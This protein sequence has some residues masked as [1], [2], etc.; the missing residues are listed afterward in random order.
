[1]KFKPNLKE[2]FKRLDY[3]KIVRLIILGI[4][5]IVMVIVIMPNFA[6]SIPGVAIGVPSP[7]NFK[8]PFSFYFEEKIPL[9]DRAERFA[10]PIKIPVFSTVG[11]LD[12]E[13]DEIENLLQFI[14]ENNTSFNF[15][16]LFT[17]NFS[18][19]LNIDELQFLKIV[20]VDNFKSIL[21]DYLWPE[22]VKKEILFDKK[23][24]KG[25]IT[26]DKIWIFNTSQS[27][28]YYRLFDDIV[29]IDHIHGVVKSIL[30]SYDI[31]EIQRNIYYKIIRYYVKDTIVY[32]EERTKIKNPEE[33]KKNDLKTIKIFIEKGESILQKGQIVTNKEV[34]IIDNVRMRIRREQ[35]TVILGIIILIA[36]YL[37]I[38]I[39]YLKYFQQRIL[40]RTSDM[41]ILCVLTIFILGISQ[42]VIKFL[43]PV[44][45][46]SLYNKNLYLSFYIIPL[47]AIS[48]II[49]LLLSYRLSII[50]SIFLSIF[51]G[52]IAGSDL[53]LPFILMSGA[54]VG[55]FSVRNAS[56]RTDI[57]KGGLFVTISY[58]VLL[59]AFVMIEKRD[60]FYIVSDMVC[61]GINGI[62]FTPVI[63]LG[64]LPFIENIGNLTSPFRLLELTDLNA[65]ILKEMLVAAPGTYQHSQ[66]VASLAEAAAIEI[67]ANTLLCKAGGY[68]H[69][70]GKIEKAEYYL[71]NQVPGENPHDKLKPRISAG[72][73][74]SHIKEGIE[75]AKE[76]GLPQAIIDIIAQHQGTGLMKVF[77]RDA[78]EDGEESDTQLS[79]EDFRYPGP[80]PQSKEAAIIMLADSSEAACRSLKRKSY[81]NIVEQI[82]KTINE[83][84]IDGQLDECDFNLKDL[85]KTVDIFSRMLSSLYHERI[86]YPEDEDIEK[87]KK[88]LQQ[89]TAAKQREDEKIATTENNN[90]STGKTKEIKKNEK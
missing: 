64:L 3:E 27:K 65:P 19:T 72:I 41:M 58:I 47:S 48:M 55:I 26:S 23:S 74:K 37:G 78:I 10:K 79:E 77:Y 89:K 12:K 67:G 63:V 51:I 45:F 83:K 24:Y 46:I 30:S 39:T 4:V 61:A 88:E 62:F 9:K 76:L 75:K 11:S 20:D 21:V 29:D 66:M 82:R 49:A 15:E 32:D 31:P 57:L 56:K 42:L 40:N 84:F 33:K 38:I 17:D 7:V 6:P 52:F 36:I 80:K 50:I 44:M 59:S 18:L 28:Y 16:K 8:S 85:S 14:S 22:L 35:Q 34:E 70:I 69:D 68:Y 25:I 87:A 54:I 90:I 13:L 81:K 2:L 71:E 86:E 60:I 1:M 5:V 43:H 53:E 73:L